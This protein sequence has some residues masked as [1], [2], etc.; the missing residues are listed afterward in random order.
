MCPSAY[1]VVFVVVVVTS[2]GQEASADLSTGVPSVP[3]VEVTTPPAI[4][5]TDP[6]AEKAETVTPAGT[7]APTGPT[8]APN[9]GDSVPDA[10]TQ[11]PIGAK[12]VADSTSA[13]TTTDAGT[14]PPPVDTKPPNTA[15]C[16][17]KI[18]DLYSAVANGKPRPNKTQEDAASDEQCCDDKIIRVMALKPPV[19]VSLSIPPPYCLNLFSK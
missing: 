6:R 9:G 15:C 16:S 18:L 2:A 17:F 3:G 5:P 4:I 1:L 12:Q 8:A 19:D 7:D 14:E 10:A 11:A 13:P